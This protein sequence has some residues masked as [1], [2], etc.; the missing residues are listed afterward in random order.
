[1]YSARAPPSLLPPSEAIEPEALYYIHRQHTRR[2]EYSDTA[3]RP[4]HR[5]VAAGGGAVAIDSQNWSQNW[6]SLVVPDQPEAERRRAGGGDAPPR[7]NTGGRAPCCSGRRR[8]PCWAAVQPHHARAA[9]FAAAAPRRGR[10]LRPGHLYVRVRVKLLG[11]I[12][13]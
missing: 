4:P 6:L 8:R 9:V 1:M 11:L 5:A 2:C 3:H 12:T 7:P 10:E 13:V